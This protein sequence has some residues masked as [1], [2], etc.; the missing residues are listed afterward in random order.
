M[1]YAYPNVG[2]KIRITHEGT[3]TSVDDSRYAQSSPSR[4]IRIKAANDRTLT[5]Y[6][7]PSLPTAIEVLQPALETDAVYKDA[8][9]EFMRWT[10]DR[11]EIF[12]SD[13]TKAFN[14]AKLPVTKVS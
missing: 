5:F 14:Y 3:V 7:G 12:A 13:Y 9:G 10:G 11:W 6:A 2:D 1:T 4:R 8:D